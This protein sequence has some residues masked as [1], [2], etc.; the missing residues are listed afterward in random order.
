MIEEPKPP[1]YR[2]GIGNDIHRIVEGR[3]LM[4]GG[5]HIPFPA[6]LL[7]H[8]DGDVVLHAVVDAL[9]GAAG[10]GDIGGFF[11]D[12]DARYKGASSASFLEHVFH[13]VHDQH[14]WDVGNVDCTVFAR[15]PKMSEVRDDIRN[16]IAWLLHI[17]VSA[18]NVK[19][20]SMNEVG[21]IGRGDAMAAQAVVLLQ[22]CK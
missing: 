3:K 18:V 5:V 17:D 2:V 19:F 21:S 22:P 6:G 1:E 7:G 8:S 13:V 12:S 16:N 14:G 9:L 15:G 4:L 20:K 10:L 11:P